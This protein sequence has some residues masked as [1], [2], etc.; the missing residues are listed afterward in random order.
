M[1]AENTS[2]ISFLPPR[3]LLTMLSYSFRKIAYYVQ[4]RPAQNDVLTEFYCN[5]HDKPISSFIHL[6]LEHAIFSQ[7]KIFSRG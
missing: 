7:L 1:N 2:M 5:I 3:G 4:I 6:P